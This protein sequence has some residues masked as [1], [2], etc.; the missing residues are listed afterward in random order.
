MGSALI[1]GLLA[2]GVPA[3]AIAVSDPSAAARSRLADRFGVSATA[4]N[5]AAVRGAGLVVLAVKPQGL[6][7]VVR[8]LR[9]ELLASRAL[10]L[11]IAAGVRVGELES[12]CGPGVP[13]VRAMPN[14][15][16]EVRAA[17]TGLYA[18]TAVGAAERALA[19]EA[20]G[21]VGTTAWVGEEALI[22]AVTALSGSGPAY[23]FL[24]AE[25]MAEAGAKLGLDPVT[26]DALAR[27]TLCGA[28]ALAARSSDP[29]ATLRTGVTSKG[30]TTEAALR[31]LGN[32]DL[33]GIVLRALE[34]ASERARELGSG[35]D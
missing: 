35:N 31:T 10:V 33:R 34:A 1:A 15:P 20:L 19:E 5:R 23:F 2:R 11:S 30:G 21:A 32:A 8:P 7:E 22:D 9:A 6:A 26:A 27:A 18:P 16:A 17:A 14:R 28:G 13:V 24:L 12:W 3:A 29:L 4:D 25:L